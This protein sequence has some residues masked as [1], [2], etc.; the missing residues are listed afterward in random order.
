MQKGNFFL[1][2]KRLTEASLSR[3]T[4]LSF[5]LPRVQF[6]KVLFPRPSLLRLCREMQKF[7]ENT[8]YYPRLPEYI[9]L[10]WMAH[11]SR[12]TLLT[13][14]LL[15]VFLPVTRKNENFRLT[16]PLLLSSDCDDERFHREIFFCLLHLSRNCFISL[17][18][19]VFNLRS[20]IPLEFRFAAEQCEVLSRA[21]KGEER[22]SRMFNLSFAIIKAGDYEHCGAPASMQPEERI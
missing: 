16:F 11:L 18:F 6:A 10:K 7:N 15:L 5:A 8:S 3:K 1:F 2:R 13:F 22:I 12:M 4:F 17:N 20:S 19:I 9:P 21:R 14:F